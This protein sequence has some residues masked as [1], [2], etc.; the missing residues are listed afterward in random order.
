[1]FYPKGSNAGIMHDTFPR[2]VLY[3]TAG[4]GGTRMVVQQ[5]R[6]VLTAGMALA[7]WRWCVRGCNID[8]AA[9]KSQVGACDLVELIIDMMER[10]PS[11]SNPPY[12]TG[13]PYTD[14]AVP[15]KQILVM[16]RPT[17]AALRKQALARAANTITYDNIAGRKVM[18]FMDVPVRTTDQLLNTEATVV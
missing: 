12:E 15:G 3:G 10:V 17:R 11:G 8:S 16:N 9:L 4:L 14:F 5:D 6:W 7:D 13:N 2:Q 18:H 1:M